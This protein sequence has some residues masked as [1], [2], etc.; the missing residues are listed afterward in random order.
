MGGNRC[1][2]KSDDRFVTLN[3]TTDKLTAT[4]SKVVIY[5]IHVNRLGHY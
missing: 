1:S 4:H 2:V 3:S 5:F